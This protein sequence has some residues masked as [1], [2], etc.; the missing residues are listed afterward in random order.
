M[1]QEIKLKGHYGSRFWQASMCR[2]RIIIE[3]FI[4]FILFFELFTFNSS[5]QMDYVIVVTKLLLLKTIVPCFVT[6]I[7]TQRVYTLNI[8]IVLV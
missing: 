6:Y 4:Y 1:F 2:N 5:C 8:R 7:F 3:I